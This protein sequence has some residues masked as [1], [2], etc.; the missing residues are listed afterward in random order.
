[1]RTIHFTIRNFFKCV[2]IVTAAVVMAGCTLKF[3]APAPEKA[4]PEKVDKATRPILME[5]TEPIPMKYAELTPVDVRTVS[6]EDDFWKPRMEIIRTKTIP[7]LFEMMDASEGRGAVLHN[8][9]VVAGLEDGAFINTFPD[10]KVYKTIEGA[11]YSLA[12]HPDPKLESQLDYLIAI[13]SAAQ[14]EDGYL[15]IKY[16]VPDPNKPE[17]WS[18][19][20]RWKGTIA[21]WPKG[22]GQFYNAGHLFEAAA[23]HY[24]VTGKRYL[25][26]IACKLADLIDSLFGPLKR[27]DFVDHPNIEVGLF[28][29]Y[30]ATGEERYLRL[31]EFIT[32]RMPHARRVDIGDGHTLMPI[33][34]QR[35]AWGHCVRQ[36]YLYTA[37]AE[38][39][40][41]TG[42]Q[43]AFTALDS[44]W[45][46]MVGKKMYI[47]GGI[48]NGTKYE[49]HGE[50]YNLPNDKAYTETC[51][52]IGVAMWNHR[53]NMLYSDAKYADIVEL[54]AYNGAL[55]G[56]SLT[57]TEY[58]YNNKLA[59]DKEKHDI[60]KKNQHRWRAI[61][62]CSVNLPR[63]IA[64]IGRWVYAKDRNA[65]YVNIY[66][67]SSANITLGDN[68]I[69]INQQTQYPWNGKITVTV[70]PQKSKTFDICLRIPGWA[71]GK[72]VPS[73]LYRFAEP[74]SPPVTLKVNGQAIETPEIKKGYVRIGRQWKK[75]DT[76]ELN[77]PMPVRRVYAH[78]DVE[79]DLGCVALMRGPIVYCF[80]GV[81]NGDDVFNLTL[82][83]DARII[84]EH[85]DDLLG[86]VT[87]LHS[88]GL[89]DPNTPVEI[90]AVPYYAWDNR[91]T[92]EMLVWLAEKQIVA[93]EAD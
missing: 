64:G 58:C 4:A 56:I 87:V 41:Y 78:P 3:A 61:W 7:D 14:E 89:R 22:F 47:T 53:M 81:D 63:F 80:E 20:W 73:N 6:I 77:L 2:A 55:S 48:G 30:R 75:G 49:Q 39:A 8:F 86:G 82:P 15:C 13:I 90:T 72:P 5:F 52:S 19:Q 37:L 59:V 18:N 69:R 60:G 9:K 85:R 42:S 46:N 74:S 40:G 84:S 34:Q 62:C 17:R 44:I 79:A 70:E 11:V 68:D 24:E 32:T 93:P 12:A 10:C 91:E 67:A 38:V 33:T 54:E 35:Q 45:D 66:V 23:L 25:L 16:Q 83:P 29:L 57:G 36:A 65:I 71:Q 76:I 50:D 92:G 31:A 26:D 43:A 27:D 51:A 1:M 21:D 28:K 88:K